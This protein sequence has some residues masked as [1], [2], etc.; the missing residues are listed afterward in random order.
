[1]YHS[2]LA[3]DLP[4]TYFFGRPDAAKLGES[5]GRLI[6]SLLPNVMIIAGLI[7]FGLIIMS[8]LKI[9]TA[10]GG[11]DPKQLAASRQQL[12]YGLI[13]FLIVVSAYFILQIISVTLTG[14]P[15]TLINPKI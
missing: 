1:M 8:G 14:S 6:S 7:F 3:I 12:F 11:S 13:G 5:P 2:I 9:I 4:G 10:S 15:D